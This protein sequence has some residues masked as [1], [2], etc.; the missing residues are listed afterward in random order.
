MHP[1]RRQQVVEMLTEAAELARAATAARERY[2]ARLQQEQAGVHPDGCWWCGRAH[3]SA[4]CPERGIP[5]GAD[6]LL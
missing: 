5:E 3:L 4:G 1:E 6:D 2:A